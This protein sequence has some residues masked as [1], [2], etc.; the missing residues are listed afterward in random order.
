MLKKKIKINTE[1]KL[2]QT[3]Q[4]LSTGATTEKAGFIDN[5]KKTSLIRLKSF[6]LRETDLINL[7]N[8]VSYVNSHDARM[9]YSNSQVI[10]GLINYISNNINDNISPLMEYIKSSS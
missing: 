3:L 10:R 1:S 8:I 6:R 5:N 2:T 4:K 7:S 9:K